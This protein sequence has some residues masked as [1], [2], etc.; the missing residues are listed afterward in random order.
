MAN[1]SDNCRSIENS[2]IM[3]GNYIQVRINNHTIRALVDTGS[4][5]SIINYDLARKLR[6]SINPLAHGHE[7]LFSANGTK[8]IV[9]GTMNVPIYIYGLVVYHT[10]KVATNITH[11]FIVGRDFLWKTH[12][13]IDYSIGKITFEDG[14]VQV[15]MLM[16]SLRDSCVVT[17][18]SVCIPAFSEMPVPVRVPHNRANQLILLESIPNFQFQKICSC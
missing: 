12:A 10:V 17:C 15:P 4:T 6:I 16:S 2:G 7:T 11:L 3:S 8:I 18:T 14:L 5:H 1:C 9:T 13:V